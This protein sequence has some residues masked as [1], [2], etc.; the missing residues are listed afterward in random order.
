MKLPFNIHSVIFKITAILAFVLVVFNVLFFIL[1]HTQMHL[2][3]KRIERSYFEI[4]RAIHLH[5]KTRPDL[6]PPEHPP[7]FDSEYMKLIDQEKAERFIRNAKKVFN[8][9]MKKNRGFSVYEENGHSLI[10]ISSG[11]EGRQKVFALIDSV[12]KASF[13]E[14]YIL[15]G[16]F[17]F[18]IMAAYVLIT[19][20]IKPLRKLHREIEKFSTGNLDVQCKSNKKD[21]IAEVSNAFENAAHRLKELIDSRSLFLR[22]IMHELKTPITKGRIS[23]EMLEGNINKE[24][25]I[26]SFTKLNSLID[27]FAKI[28][29]LN[30][31]NFTLNRQ[32]YNLRALMDATK[33]ILFVDRGVI[34]ETK[35]GKITCDI[36]LMSVAFKNLIENGIKYSTDST[37]IV[38]SD[39]Q[40]I[41]FKNQGE[42]IKASIE[43]I[44]KPF[45]RVAK[46]SDSESLGLGL[47]IVKE[48]LN[49]HNLALQ[50]AYKDGYNVFSVVLSDEI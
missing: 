39:E 48:I 33:E 3:E 50:Y 12:E 2:E 29:R 13:L 4:A 14:L 10:S 8:V 34:D 40:A 30:S 27:E 31:S 46:T 36:E 9:T 21:E 42:K 5:T 24:R 32:T 22:M 23:A 11:E 7:V 20:S 26:K 38:S 45:Y 18:V 16:A 15:W 44:T 17:N 37:C 49:I 28:E 35:E 1:L 41:Y 6:P 19:N 43:E 47:Y 25:I